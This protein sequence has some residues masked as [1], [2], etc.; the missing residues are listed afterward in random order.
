MVGGEVLGSSI[1]TL[2]MKSARFEE[3]PAACVVSLVINK[4]SENSITRVSSSTTA[5][6][7]FDLINIMSPKASIN[8]CELLVYLYF[9]VLRHQGH[10]ICTHV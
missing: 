4:T 2:V 1:V 8:T 10:Y 7:F 5:L 3:V 6:F 9:T